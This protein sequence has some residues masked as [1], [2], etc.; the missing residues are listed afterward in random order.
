MMCNVATLP[1]LCYQRPQARH[2]LNV[3]GGDQRG[4]KQAEQSS[5]RKWDCKCSSA[6]SK[7][8]CGHK[9]LDG[10]VRG[11]KNSFVVKA[12]GWC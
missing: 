9:L 3:K 2:G 1:L 8:L 11:R 6:L 12:P 5:F 4:L 10:Y 7:P